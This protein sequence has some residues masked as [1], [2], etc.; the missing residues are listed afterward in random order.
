MKFRK[1]SSICLLFGTCL[2][3]LSMFAISQVAHADDGLDDGEN[4]APAPG[5]CG[6]ACKFN[7]S[8]VTLWDPYD[9]VW[10]TDCGGPQFPAPA[11]TTPKAFG[12]GCLAAPSA[13]CTTCDGCKD[14]LITAGAPVCL[15]N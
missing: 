7:C 13:G 4:N 9:G 10:V 14:R 6:P 5:D 15:C 3:A 11:P 8:A 12:W 1:L 2:L